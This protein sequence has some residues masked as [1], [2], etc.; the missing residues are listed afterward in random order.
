MAVSGGRVGLVK[1]LR[2]IARDGA[3]CR[4]MGG[5]STGDSLQ[6]RRST[7]R[8]H[9][10]WLAQFDGLWRSSAFVAAKRLP[11]R[12]H[13]RYGSI[14]RDIVSMA[15]CSITIAP[16]W[17]AIAPPPI[18]SQSLLQQLVDVGQVSQT[19]ARSE[20]FQG[21]GA[22]FPPAATRP[23]NIVEDH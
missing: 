10:R 12:I 8:I 11:R 18:A 3:L 2:L 22:N 16:V 19:E 6:H 21:R 15:G 20:M 5:H 17:R 1:G 4:K 13:T 9:R 14:S 23:M 7:D